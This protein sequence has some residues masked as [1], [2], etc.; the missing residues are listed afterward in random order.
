MKK[1]FLATLLTLT[2]ACGEKRTLTTPLNDLTPQPSTETI[3]AF[4]LQECSDKYTQLQKDLWPLELV[5]L[6]PFCVDEAFSARL[7]ELKSFF[8]DKNIERVYLVDAAQA[9]LGFDVESVR[10]ARLSVNFSETKDQLQALWQSKRS[11]LKY[12]FFKTPSWRVSQVF[13]DG[14]VI[15]KADD[16]KKITSVVESLNKNEEFV[17]SIDLMRAD[18]GEFPIYI[19][20]TKCEVAADG[21]YLLIKPRSVFGTSLGAVKNCL[22]KLQ[23][24]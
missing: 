1:L 10:S 4:K 23:E 14:V 2:A 3:R 9:Q 5:A 19:S 7:K 15:T 18:K 12:D 8:A 20:F 11:E 17:R 16:L 6:A 13:I 22:K 21:L 24:N